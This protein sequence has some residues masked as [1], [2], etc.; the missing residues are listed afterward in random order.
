MGWISA[1]RV[2][3]R[4]AQ[5]SDLTTVQE[6]TKCPPWGLAGGKA[7]AVNALIVNPD[8]PEAESIN[9][10]N[11]KPIRAGSL[12][13]VRTGG[14]GG[15][16]NPFERDPE[17]VRLDVVRGYVSR[18]AA[19]HEYGVVLRPGTLEIDVEATRRLRS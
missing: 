9:K 12:I 11:A 6:R 19:Q 7:A 15:Y 3:R 1:A 10:V 4:C 8:T 14:G 18:E 2:N 5:T 17:L 16:G 13:S